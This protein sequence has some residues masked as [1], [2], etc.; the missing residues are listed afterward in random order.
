MYMPGR[1]RTG[2]RPSRTVMSFAEYVVS[3]IK[4]ALQ[5]DA[6]R[7]RGS[8]SESAVGGSPREARRGRPRDQLAELLVLDRRGDLGRRRTLPIAGLDDGARR[9]RERG[10]AGLRERSLREPHR[11]HTEPLGDLRTALTELE[12]PDRVRG[13]DLQRPVPRDAR[14]P[15]VAGDRLADRLLPGGDHPRRLDDGPVARQLRV[16]VA[17][18]SLRPPPAPIAGHAPLPV[19]RPPP[20][21]ARPAWR[22]SSSR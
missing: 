13:V 22:R 16:D 19:S 20:G 11:P 4:K 6:S 8:V 2:S 9:L 17:A 3:A 18:E 5:I 14:R 15:G 12:R 1:S 10:L 7:A 21:R